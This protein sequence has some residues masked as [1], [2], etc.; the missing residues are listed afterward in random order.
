VMSGDQSECDQLWI[1]DDGNVT[2]QLWFA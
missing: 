1:T 2:A